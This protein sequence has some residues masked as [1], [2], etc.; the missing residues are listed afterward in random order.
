MLTDSKRYNWL[1]V[2]KAFCIYFILF[3]HLNS[4]N[5]FAAYVFSFMVHAFFFAAGVTAGRNKDKTLKDY[6]ILRFKRLM[7]PYFIF[8]IVAMIVK[9]VV[10]GGSIAELSYM[11][12]YGYRLKHY[13][14][15]LWFLPCLYIVSLYYQT[16]LRFVKNKWLRM[17]VCV[18]ISFVFRLFSEGNV[19]PWGIDNAVKFLIYYG[20]GDFFADMLNGFSENPKLI[21]KKIWPAGLF[22]VCLLLSYILH[23]KGYTYFTD[24]AGIPNVYIVMVVLGCFYA[25]VG[26]Y[27]FSIISIFLQNN[28]ALQAVGKASLII[29][30]LQLPIDRLVYNTV[31]VLGLQLYTDTQVQCLLVTVIFVWLGVK[32]YNFIQQ[33]F[34]AAMGISPNKKENS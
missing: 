26:I 30:C 16:L 1:D 14:T 25:F 22:A 28:K 20:A 8:G 7:V 18:I 17:A 27:L 32:A 29:C 6:A 12:I 9:L 3:A 33:Y 5:R 4:S 19:L 31:Q 10:D 24:L 23:Q 34:P 15:T 2:L 13:A 21:F 11:L